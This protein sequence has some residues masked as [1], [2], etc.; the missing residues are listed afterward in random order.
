MNKGAVVVTGASTGIGE[1]CALWLDK[2]GFQVFAGIR[3]DRD[4]QALKQKASERLNPIF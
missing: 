4:A 1:T 2:L 3:T